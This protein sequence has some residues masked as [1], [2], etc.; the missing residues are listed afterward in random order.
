MK[1]LLLSAVLI[2]AVLMGFSQ[3]DQRAKS[4]LEEVTK[5]TRSWQTIQATFDYIMDNK[6]EGIHEE[7]KGEIL[8]KGSKYVLKLSELGLEI[9]CD[10]KAVWSFMKD[11]NEV[12]IT[13]IDDES[14]EL[15]NPS[16]L[17]TIYEQGFNYEFVEETVSGGKSIY[18]IDL[19]P[20][21]KGTD[22]KKIRLHVDKKQMMVIRAEMS[23]AEGNDYIVRVN[24]LKTNVPADD[25]LFI[26]DVSKHPGVE[27]IDLR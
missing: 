27:K 24:N 5:T 2:F 9:Y 22:Y 4:I 20:E 14:S 3:Q 10:G 21:T 25:R 6:E 13:S 18:V 7:N 1:K 26:F 19:F 11:A 16:K 17:F 23:G 12:N 8:M 15:M